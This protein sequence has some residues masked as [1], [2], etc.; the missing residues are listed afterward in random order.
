VPVPVVAGTV[1]AIGPDSLTLKTRDGSA[2]T[3]TLTGATTYKLG[4]ADGKK[5]DVKVGSVVIASGTEGSA[6]AF[7]AKTVRIEVHLDRI[8][9]EVTATTTNSITVKQRDG[10]T[11][12]IKVATDTK[13]AV[14]DDASP[15]LADIVV[16]MRVVALGTLNADGSLNAAFIKAG[17]PSK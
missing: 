9:G 7:T 17:K 10:T 1:T 2:R 15:A 6:N 5:S 4:Q 16:G 14:R 11:A 12:T 3:V 13:I 8:G